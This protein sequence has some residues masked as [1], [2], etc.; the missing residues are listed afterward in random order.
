[1]YSVLPERPDHFE[2]Q[3]KIWM[4]SPGL[5]IVEHRAGA[6]HIWFWKLFEQYVFLLEQR[7]DLSIPW[8]HNRYEKIRNCRD[9]YYDFSNPENGS[10]WKILEIGKERE[11]D[12][13][14]TILFFSFF[15]S[16]QIWT[17]GLTF[18]EQMLYHS[19]MPLASKLRIL[20]RNDGL[21]KM[22]IFKWGSKSCSFYKS[23]KF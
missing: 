19:A 1:M 5:G 2:R 21:N 8:S 20:T 15:D 22:K 4:E 6:D 14:L 11:W 18:A 13:K 7:I 12:P 23:D 16:S 3:A 9:T 17:Q 10:A